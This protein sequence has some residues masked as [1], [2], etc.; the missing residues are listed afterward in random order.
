MDSMYVSHGELT[1]QD[2]TSLME[3]EGSPVQIHFDWICTNEPNTSRYN[4]PEIVLEMAFDIISKTAKKVG[5]R[6]GPEHIYYPSSVLSL[7]WTETWMLQS[8]AQSSPRDHLS[9]EVL[10]EDKVAPPFSA[11]LLADA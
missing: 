4:Q 10:S 5:F 3:N 9:W 7:F 8:L 2:R 6:G 11:M 1:E